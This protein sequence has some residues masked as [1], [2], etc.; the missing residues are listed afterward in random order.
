MTQLVKRVLCDS[1][2][3]GFDPRI[4]PHLP[5]V[6]WT[7]REFPKLDVASSI[8]AGEIVTVVCQASSSRM[9]WQTTV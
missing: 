9:F 7:E 4:P 3:G 6:Q 5:V 1:I 8:L 2:F